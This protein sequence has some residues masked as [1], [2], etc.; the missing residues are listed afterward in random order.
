MPIGNFS[1][2]PLGYANT[3]IYGILDPAQILGTSPNH[4]CHDN[5][6]GVNDTGTFLGF[7]K[8][9]V[10]TANVDTTLTKKTGAG[11]H[12]EKLKLPSATSVVAD[13]VGV[14]IYRNLGN[15]NNDQNSWV[16]DPH[17]SQAF[18]GGFSAYYP[19]EAVTFCS[20]VFRPGIWVAADLANPIA[21]GSPV[22][23]LG[24]ALATAGNVSNLGTLTVP[25]S[26]V[27][28][29]TFPYAGNMQGYGDQEGATGCVLV[30]FNLN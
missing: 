1:T 12:V 27:L 3:D 7:G 6:S 25:N 2:N 29:A 13:L 26:R 8:F 20:H 9:L 17:S 5:Q 14:T 11:L 18:N 28:S 16:L 22:K 23:V 15:F 21:V 4:N 30:S 10:S 24:N 19:T